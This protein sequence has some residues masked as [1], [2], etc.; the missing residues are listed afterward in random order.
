MSPSSLARA[1]AAALILLGAQSATAQQAAPP[2]A[3][4]AP[5]P[6]QTAPAA[7]DIVRLNNGAEY[8]G[9]LA[10]RVPDSHVVI[11]TVVGDTRRFEWAEVAY[12]GPVQASIASPA[13]PAP[14]ALAPSPQSADPSA[15]SEAA[16]APSQSDTV[17]V[18]LRG[19]PAGVTWMAQRQQSGERALALCMPPCKAELPKGPYRLGLQ[20][21]GRKTAWSPST[22]ALE[23]P[24]IFEG[25]Y[26][27]RRG[28]RIAGGVVL[29]GSLAT[30]IALIAVGAQSN[31]TCTASASSVSSD[32][33]DACESSVSTPF[34]A[35]GVVL[36]LVGVVVGAL[37]LSKKDRA[38]ISAARSKHV[39][40]GGPQVAPLEPLEPSEPSSVPTETPNIALDP[41]TKARA[42]Q[43]LPR[44]V[45]QVELVVKTDTTGKLVFVA[46]DPSIDRDA[47]RCLR[48]VLVG[49][50]TEVHR[51]TVT[52][53]LSR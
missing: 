30:A 5:A 7:N 27:S 16:A 13:A 4:I 15:A 19:F 42:W 14:S 3:P 9:T 37:L 33:G 2:T 11:L 25:T 40:S 12:A 53:E 20:I 36:G 49:T 17:S 38:T 23:E 35:S 47:W 34:I 50:E 39:T 8:R 44:T 1:L 6:P 21:P 52:L 10:E 41:R 31:Q 51:S 29:G 26:D 32:W 22:F 45:A 48:D 43:C 24:D 28:S 46:P 18:D